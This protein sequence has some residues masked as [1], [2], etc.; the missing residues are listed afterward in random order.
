VEE[1]QPKTKPKTD[2]KW[3]MSPKSH[4]NNWNPFSSKPGLDVGGFA[5]TLIAIAT[6]E[7]TFGYFIQLPLSAARV[8]LDKQQLFVLY[9]AWSLVS[10]IGFWFVTNT[11]I[12]RWSSIYGF[13]TIPRWMK[14]VA[15]ILLL[16]P[17]L[18]MWATVY[19]LLYSKEGAVFQDGEKKT[20]IL[21]TSAATLIVFHTAFLGYRMVQHEISFRGGRV[22][23]LEETSMRDSLPPGLV[24]SLWLPGAGFYV[25]AYPYLSPVSK[26][27]LSLYA[28][29]A[30]SK[31]IGDR[32]PDCE[33]VYL[34][35]RIPNCYFDSYRGI[36][37][38]R[39]FVSP[40]FGVIFESKYRQSVM[41]SAKPEKPMESF[42]Y[43]AVS[44]ENLIALLE[45]G[46]LV[47]ERK[48]F[49][50]PV[51]LLPF[52]GSPE[53]VAISLGQDSQRY[54]L[55]LKLVP[56]LEPQLAKLKKSLDDIKGALAPAEEKVANDKMTELRARLK[57]LASD[58]L[59]VR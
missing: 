41:K 29:F 35:Q 43:N 23:L 56:L 51:G 52:L 49:L 57:A 15:R 37:L 13:D 30:R 2:L 28:D 1:S 53:L 3:K 48:K 19:T 22:T 25:H 8:A 27:F 7:F 40:A 26:L 46:D 4:S 14:L 44:V 39:P 42:A 55:S 58:P 20:T 17:L 12:K 54:V 5:T 31:M 45:P 24:R 32:V 21:M 11:F 59:S 18:S 6:V 10:L 34:E 36:A 33:S 47:Y 50:H 9:A 38:K 16:S